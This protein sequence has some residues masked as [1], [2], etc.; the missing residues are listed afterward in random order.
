M[1]MCSGG[2]VVVSH[3][4]RMVN[5]DICWT[6]NL[7]LTLASD[8]IS[9]RHVKVYNL[10]MCF[11]RFDCNNELWSSKKVWK[12]G[13]RRHRNAKRDCYRNA[14]SPEARWRIWGIWMNIGGD[15][16][17]SPIGVGMKLRPSILGWQLFEKAL[18]FIPKSN[19]SFVCLVIHQTLIE[20]LLHSCRRVWR[21]FWLNLHTRGLEKKRKHPL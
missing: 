8:F 14:V 13:E 19:I 16:A 7:N 11:L 9:H 2:G 4:D 3:L 18:L 20:N 6:S 12:L 17:P 10:A 1:C 15:V 21:S 5:L